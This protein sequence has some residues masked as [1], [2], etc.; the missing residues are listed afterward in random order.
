LKCSLSKELDDLEKAIDKLDLEADISVSKIEEKASEIPLVLVDCAADTLNG[1][2][3]FRVP[4]VV[5][6]PK[7]KRGTISL[8]KKI[9]KKKKSGKKKGIDPTKPDYFFPHSMLVKLT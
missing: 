4:Q 1:K 8:D 5:K 2:I 3:S 9:E 6:S 7:S